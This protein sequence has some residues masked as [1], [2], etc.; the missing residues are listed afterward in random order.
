MKCISSSTSLQYAHKRFSIAGTF[1]SCLADSMRR[2]CELVLSLVKACLYLWFDI[3]YR[4]VS[5]PKP[6][7]NNLYVLVHSIMNIIEPNSFELIVNR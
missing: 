3:L 5:S 4:Y 1:C 7:L 2:A 6:N